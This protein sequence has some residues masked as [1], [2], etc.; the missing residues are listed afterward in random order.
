MSY[1][2]A[3]DEPLSFNL[4]SGSDN[5]DSDDDDTPGP[6]SSSSAPGSVS[7]APDNRATDPGSSSVPWPSRSSTPDNESDANLTP[8][9][10]PSPGPALCRSTHC[11]REILRIC[12]LMK[13]RIFDTE[14]NQIQSRIYY[15]PAN[16]CI[17]PEN[18]EINISEIDS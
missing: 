1:G 4:G 11:R 10:S 9:A 18:I 5:D 12:E 3:P 2:S 15:N 6:G 14:M 7:A 8:R 16:V 17:T 13:L